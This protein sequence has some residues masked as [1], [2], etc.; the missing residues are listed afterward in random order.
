MTRPVR[1][2]SPMEVVR[3]VGKGVVSL[4][5]R[6]KPVAAAS[7][8]EPIEWVLATSGTDLGTS[9]TVLDFVFEDFDY[10]GDTPTFDLNANSNVEIFKDGVYTMHLWETGIVRNAGVS[11]VSKI[12]ARR[13]SGETPKVLG[14]AAFSTGFEI[15]VPSRIDSTTDAIDVTMSPTSP[16]W[17]LPMAFPNGTFG[18]GTLGPCEIEIQCY[19]EEDGVGV[20]TTAPTMRMWITRLGPS[21]NP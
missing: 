20:A 14:Y 7:A 10:D 11:T 1:P 18:P 2:A 19:H 6:P 9:Y 21:Y 15:L 8:Q 5:N 3:K 13:V 17:T 4:G 12:Q 16:H